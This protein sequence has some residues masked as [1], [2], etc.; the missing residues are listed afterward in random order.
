MIFNLWWNNTY[1]PYKKSND[2]LIY[3]DIPSNHSPHIVTNSNDWSFEPYDNLRKYHINDVPN[4]F[5]LLAF[6]AWVIRK[7][8]N[9]DIFK[10]IWRCFYLLLL[11]R[12]GAGCQQDESVRNIVYNNWSP[13]YS[14]IWRKFFNSQMFVDN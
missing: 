11:N 3:I 5:I 2:K 1:C 14:N 6:S 12:L 8:Q 9:Q 13:Y 4:G 7:E 10:L